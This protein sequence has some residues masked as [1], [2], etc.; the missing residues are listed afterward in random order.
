M[1]LEK[2]FTVYHGRD[3]GVASLAMSDDLK[4][5][6]EWHRYASSV[7]TGSDLAWG[8]ERCNDILNANRGTAINFVTRLSPGRYALWGWRSA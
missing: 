5:L 4:K 6:D 2:Y 7:H 8:V 3:H 1:I